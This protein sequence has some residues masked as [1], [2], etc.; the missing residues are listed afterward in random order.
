MAQRPKPPP[1]PHYYHRHYGG[2]A[3]EA[4]KPFHS[5]ENIFRDSKR[6][7][8]SS[9]SPRRTVAYQANGHENVPSNH[10]PKIEAYPRHHACPRISTSPPPAS[11]PIIRIRNLHYEVNEQD[12]RCLFES[13]APV[14]KVVV[15]YDRSGRS[16]GT[17]SIAFFSPKDADRAQERF[18]NVPLDGRA[19]QIESSLLVPPSM[20]ERIVHHQEDRIPH[21]KG[22]VYH[23]D[24]HLHHQD[25]RV[26]RQEDRIHEPLPLHHSQSY[27]R[28]RSIDYS[29]GGSN[30][31]QQRLHARPHKH[32]TQREER[33]ERMRLDREMDEYMMQTPDEN[34]R[35][36]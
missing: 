1:H 21:Q 27:H 31:H 10:H 9:E 34:E 30:C 13:V 35:N 23:Q 29:N 22:R 26:R 5:K 16:N 18:H 14:G 17:A 2:E 8:L 32:F 6:Y 36:Y 33:F 19:M 24:D 7:A 3:Y 25:D 20:S 15:D 4:Q 12:L 11:A 28:H